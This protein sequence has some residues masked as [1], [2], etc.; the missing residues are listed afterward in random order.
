MGKRTKRPIIPEQGKTFSLE[1]LSESASKNR[2][3]AKLNGEGT[4]FWHEGG[5]NDYICGWCGSNIIKGFNELLFKNGAAKCNKCQKV[6]SL[7]KIATYSPSQKHRAIQDGKLARHEVFMSENWT[8][9]KELSPIIEKINDEIYSNQQPEPKLLY[10]YTSSYGLI[11]IVE[12]KKLWMT[13]AYYLNDSQEMKH[14]EGLVTDYVNEISST[15]TNE[16]KELV[17]RF[18]SSLEI[19]PVEGRVYVTCFC[20]N[21]DLL[22]QWRAYGNNGS[23]YSIGINPK[24]IGQY[25]NKKTLLRKVLYDPGEQRRLIKLV[26]DEVLELWRSLSPTYATNEMTT[27]AL[28]K[29]LASFLENHLSEFTFYFKHEAFKE[30]REWRAIEFLDSEDDIDSIRLRTSGSLLIP[31]AESNLCSFDDDFPI[32]PIEE[33]IY[34]PTLLDDL[35]EASVHT[36]LQKNNLSHVEVRRSLAPYRT[37]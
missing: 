18:H 12:S 9:L 8:G 28:M 26:I 21:G 27:D 31:Y 23:G 11:N 30:E 7:S 15:L 6:S 32:L 24:H 37:Y 36:L 3:V 25:Q 17:G 1:R 2:G 13:H 34:G 33:V 22:S 35:T 14:S 29:I 5:K 10:H 16:E 20:E 19:I 4:T